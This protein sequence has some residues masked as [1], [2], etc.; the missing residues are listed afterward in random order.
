M[1]RCQGRM[2][3]PSSPIFVAGVTG[4]AVTEAGV[5]TPRPPVKP[6]PLAAFAHE[7]H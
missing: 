1:G 5:F 6:V 2:W 4:R 3:G 7:A